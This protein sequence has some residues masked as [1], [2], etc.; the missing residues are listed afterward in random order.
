MK[1]LIEVEEA[2]KLLA[3]INISAEKREVFVLDAVNKFS[4]ENVFAPVDLPPFDRSTRDG[5]A[6]LSEDVVSASETNPVKLKIV[7]TIEAGEFK[8]VRISSGECVKIATGAVIPEKSDA[9]VMVENCEEHGGY[10][11]VKKAVAPRENVMLKGSDVAE[12]ELVVREGERL[13]PEKI[14]LLSGLGL[15]KVKIYDLRIAVFSTGN[16]IALPGERLDR[17]KIYDVNGFAIVSS[18]RNLGFSAEFLGILKDDV[19]EMRRRLLEASKK[20]G[21]VVTSGA[22]SAGEK[23]LLIE[24]VKEIGEIVFHGVRIKPGKPF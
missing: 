15:R 22:T 1:R 19:K 17:G 2:K 13:T 10:V 4:A 5:Y 16:E 8:S 23:D 7:G 6:V 12:G 18:L 9:V 14:G 24:A 11:F 21:V 3:A 20:Y